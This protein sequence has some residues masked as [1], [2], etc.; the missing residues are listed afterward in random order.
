MVWLVKPT[1]LMLMMAATTQAAAAGTCTFDNKGQCSAECPESSTCICDLSHDPHNAT[2][3]GCFD[4]PLPNCQRPG[5][6]NCC[7]AGC[8]DGD[9]ECCRKHPMCCPSALLDVHSKLRPS[10]V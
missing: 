5:C 1:I 7:N 10:I 9:E 3:P 2:S 4:V 6:C 8:P